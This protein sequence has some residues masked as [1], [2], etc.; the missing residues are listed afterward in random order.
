MSTPAL[1]PAIVLAGGLGLRL[2]PITGDRCPKP[3]VPTPSASGD[4]PFLE[5]PLAWLRREGVQDVVICIG[6]K[7]ER[8]RSHFGDGRDHG[9]AI[10]Y[11][12][13]GE[14]DTGARCRSA[15][16]L[17]K[18]DLALVV[19]GDVLVDFPLRPFLRGLIDHPGRDAV[20]AVAQD[21]SGMPL[22]TGF[23]T[24]GTVSDFNRNGA[25]G[26]LTG[27]EAGVLA[28]R[29]RA[30]DGSTE[31]A[32]YSLVAHV[33]P[34]LIANRSL[35]ASPVAGSFFDIGTPAGYARFCAWSAGAEPAHG[36]LAI[37]P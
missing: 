36:A 9:L 32:S 25:A 3:M 7:G 14:A 8:I 24:D 27:V 19:C 15:F 5:W 23:D 31:G 12:D 11:D 10:T 18:T 35:A 29:R 33:Y 6:H 34:R 26:S 1:P 20:L 13:A 17:L 2:R 37:A 22:N 16:G 21:A 4:R 28:I 30:L